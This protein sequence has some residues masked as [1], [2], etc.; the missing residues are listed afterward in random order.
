MLA[1]DK[2]WYRKV[3]RR[4]PT[5][6]TTGTRARA[7]AGDA[8]AQ[9][10]LWL[11]YE[12]AE[13]RSQDFVQA[14]LWYRKAA[15]QNHALAQC[16][17]ALM[18]AKGQGVPR[19]EA[20]AARWLRKAADQGDPGAQ[21]HLGI[22]CH[23]SSVGWPRVNAS[24]SRI[25]A[26]AWLCLAAAQGYKDSIAACDLVALGMTGAEVAQGNHRAAILAKGT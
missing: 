3:F 14:A 16:H 18:Y 21:F 26:Y 24:E 5:P 20:E 10:A 2:R 9:F 1:M 22:R 19:D 17:L 7:E 6:D 23:R 4:A 11:D 13:G 25:E 12:E 15:D 8:N